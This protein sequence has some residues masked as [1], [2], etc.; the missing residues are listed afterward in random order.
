MFKEEQKMLLNILK[1]TLLIFLNLIW[2]I[3]KAILDIINLYSIVKVKKVIM[4]M[5]NVT[6]LSF[7][8]DQKVMS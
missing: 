3:T 7:Q 4:I 5:K 6:V 8:K 1:I 2:Q